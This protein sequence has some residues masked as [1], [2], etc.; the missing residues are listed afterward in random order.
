MKTF[1]WVLPRASPFLAPPP[2]STT[3]TLPLP[4][5]F[6]QIPL[7][8]FRFSSSE[9]KRLRCVAHALE[10]SSE[11]GTRLLCDAIWTCCSWALIVAFD[12]AAA[13]SWASL[14]FWIANSCSWIAGLEDIHNAQRFRSTCRSFLVVSTSSLFLRATLD[15]AACTRI[16]R[17][18]RCSHAR[19][20]ALS[21]S[22]SLCRME[23]SLSARA[24]TFR[25]LRAKISS[26]RLRVSSI[27]EAARCSS[28]W[29]LCKRFCSSWWSSSA[30]FRARFAA[31]SRFAPNSV[32]SCNTHRTQFDAILNS[33]SQRVLDC[34]W[35]CF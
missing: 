33:G 28:T 3:A 17:V 13:A 11:W 21:T 24:F 30:F 4:W 27:F 31:S 8:I 12:W 16:A 5:L 7:Q 32:G 15:V 29:S 22:S 20:C 18:S 14:S 34:Q 1:R 10:S 6:Y 19:C 35:P 2:L 9:N 23:A 25:A 26:A